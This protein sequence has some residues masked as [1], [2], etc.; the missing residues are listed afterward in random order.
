MAGSTRNRLAG[1]GKVGRGSGF[2]FLV[3]VGVLGAAVA[4]GQRGLDSFM[5]PLAPCKD[6]IVTPAVPDAPFFRPGSPQRTVIAEPGA[7][8]TKLVLSGMVSGV[9]CGFIKGAKLDFWQADA[10]GAYD[11]A[12]FR[13]RGH[14]LTNADGRYR[15]ETVVPGPAGGRPRALN[16]RIDVEGKTLLTTQLFFPD[17]P[18]TRRDTGFR[19]DLTM[20]FVTP[21]GRPYAAGEPRT[22]TFDFLLNR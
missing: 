10:K 19:A 14:Q 1:V 15:L 13:L 21:G 20:T 7:P 6:P 2:V 4:A 9:T 16:V 17:E 12:G 8:G 11:L 18:Q 5:V 22:A 3:L